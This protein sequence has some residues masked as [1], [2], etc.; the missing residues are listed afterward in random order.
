[1]ILSVAAAVVSVRK[2]VIVA[3]A[4][5]GEVVP[6]RTNDCYLDVRVQ[7]RR[8]TAAPLGNL[9]S[10]VVK[11]LG[12]WVLPVLAAQGAQGQE[13]VA[14]TNTLPLKLLHKGQRLAVG[15]DG[16]LKAPCRSEVLPEA[17]API[18]HILQAEW[19]QRLGER[20]CSQVRWGE[21]G[22]KVHGL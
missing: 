7:Q 11:A 6:R 14:H 9:Q 15:L 16:L 20:M 8:R 2:G 19:A 17:N 13:N 21:R 1:M 22:R 18:D 3:V 5:A 4:R 10:A 12:A